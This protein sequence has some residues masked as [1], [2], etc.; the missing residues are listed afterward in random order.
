MEG[1]ARVGGWGSVDSVRFGKD[2]P[3]VSEMC[4]EIFHFNIQQRQLYYP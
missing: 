3:D 4:L 1:T 2:V